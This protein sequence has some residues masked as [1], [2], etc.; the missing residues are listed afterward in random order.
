MLQELKGVT[1]SQYRGRN[2]KTKQIKD[3]ET[4]LNR[5][6]VKQTRNSKK[7]RRTD[8]TKSDRPHLRGIFVGFSSRLVNIIDRKR[9]EL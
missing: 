2:D 7:M 3:G 1:T 9:F 8:R 4:M 5:I 6:E